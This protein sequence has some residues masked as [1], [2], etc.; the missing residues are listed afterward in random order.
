MIG[1][2]QIALLALLAPSIINAGFVGSTLVITP[3]GRQSI[4]SL[5]KGTSVFAYNIEKNSA[6]S[7]KIINKTEQLVERPIILTFE[8]GETLITTIDQL[9]YCMYKKPLTNQEKILP[10]TIQDLF[11]LCSQKK[12]NNLPSF[13]NDCDMK[14]L[15]LNRNDQGTIIQTWVAIKEIKYSEEADA[16]FTIEVEYPYAFVVEQKN[17]VALCKDA[18]SDDECSII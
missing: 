1:F 16:F 7:T 12:I 8:N 17:F 14:V 9:L 11:T 18:N 3:E 2:K 6:V 5:K 13:S 4:S 15:R 10:L